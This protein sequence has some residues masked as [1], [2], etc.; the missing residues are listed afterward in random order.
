MGEVYKARDTRLD[1]IVAI[2]V[3]PSH[4]ASSDILR[5]RF[6][7]EARTVASLSHPH[8]CMLHD[9]GRHQET[10]FLV[11]EFLE[12]E[13]LEERLQRGA[14]DIRQALQI[15][16]DTADALSNAHRAGIVHRDH[17]PGN[18]MLSRSGA[19]LLDFGLAKPPSPAAAGMLSIMPTTPPGLT[20]EGAISRHDGGALHR[21]RV[22]TRRQPN[23]LVP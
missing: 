17:K 11:M 23:H 9:V 3:L 1:R 5:E 7:R 20:V 21:G 15:A 16:I 22:D 12:G 8:I 14:L 4:L 18:I 6:E 10:D 13:T 19:K 2:E